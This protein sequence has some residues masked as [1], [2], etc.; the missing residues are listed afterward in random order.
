MARLGQPAKSQPA[1]SRKS[2]AKV[3]CTIGLLPRVASTSEAAA[4]LC[5]L[6]DSHKR[7]NQDSR[8]PSKGPAFQ[9]KGGQYRTCRVVEV[10]EDSTESG[11]K[12]TFVSP[13][14]QPVDLSRARPKTN[15]CH[16][17]G[18]RPSQVPTYV[19]PSSSPPA[20][21]PVAPY[22]P[23][24]PTSVFHLKFLRPMKPKYKP[25]PI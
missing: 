14:S 16:E 12:K 4:S 25:R 1:P 9:R 13:L 18:P 17:A 10:N 7:E 5:V 24:E 8:D 11:S 20:T 6:S 2:S 19:G 15:R 23:H 22:I 21:S 3:R